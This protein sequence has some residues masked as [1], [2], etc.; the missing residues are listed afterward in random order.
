MTF[1][2]QG[3]TLA[4][5]ELTMEGDQAG[6]GLIETRLLLLPE[7]WGSRCE[8]PRP[9]GLLL[10]KGLKWFHGSIVIVKTGALHFLDNL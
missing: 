3:L 4:V 8:Q 7:N 2:K 6:F 5:P 9:E 10:R 1:I